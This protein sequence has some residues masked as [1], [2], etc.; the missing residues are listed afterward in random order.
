MCLHLFRL[1]VIVLKIS[2]NIDNYTLLVFLLNNNLKI[3]LEMEVIERCMASFMSMPTSFCEKMDPF[4]FF[5]QRISNFGMRF[6]NII[7]FT[8]VKYSGLISQAD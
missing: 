1:V 7:M 4:F 6:F 5:Q 3:E 8:T 2:I